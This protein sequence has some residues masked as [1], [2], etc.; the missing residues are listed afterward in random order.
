MDLIND[1]LKYFN[2][3]FQ[4]HQYIP[5]HNFFEKLTFDTKECINTKNSIPNSH[6]GV[7]EM[8]T[9]S[10]AYYCYY[11]IDNIHIQNNDSKYSERCKKVCV[12]CRRR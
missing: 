7:S 10:G 1:S 6:T 5:T 3:F 9:Q 4:I 12:Q 11:F 8:N 2:F